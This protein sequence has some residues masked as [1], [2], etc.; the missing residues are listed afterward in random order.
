MMH[1]TSVAVLM[2]ARQRSTPRRWRSTIAGVL[3]VLTLST[4]SAC[5]RHANRTTTDSTATQSPKVHWSRAYIV[6]PAGNAPAVMYL[7]IDNPGAKPDTLLRVTTPLVDV[8]TLHANMTSGSM[9]EH[10]GAMTMAS[11]STIEVPADTT[12]TLAPGGTHVMLPNPK[13]AVTRGDSVPVTLIFSRAGAIDG[14][15]AVIAYADVD[16]ATAVAPSAA[17][18]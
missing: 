9:K 17:P 11:V 18:R 4:L 10:E 15:A 5:K 7:T 12:V 14:K 6:V 16:T 2:K 3:G 1:D 13:Y 8:A